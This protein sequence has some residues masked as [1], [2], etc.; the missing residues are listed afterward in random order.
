VTIQKMAIHLRLAFAACVLFCTGVGL[1]QGTSTQANAEKTTKLKA[2]LAASPLLALVETNLPIQLDA[3]E[4]LG[5]VSWVA[6]DQKSGI[7]WLIQR[8][9]KADPVMAVDDE[10][11]VIHAFGK[12]LYTIPHAIRLDP[13]GNVWTVDAGSSTVIKFSPTGKK[14]MQIDV[15]GM[16]AGCTQFCGTTDITFAPNGH[17][18]ISDG[19]RNARILEYAADGTKVREW[20][21]RGTGPGEFHLPHSIV[22]DEN[23]ILYVADRE[24]GRIE[25]FDLDGK[26]LGEI[27]TLGRTY[28][29][30]LGPKG[31]LWAGVAPLDEPTGAAGWLVK[32]DR[33][34]GKLLGYVPVTDKNGLHSVEID[35][36]GNPMTVV[37]NKVIMFKP[38]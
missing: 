38:R 3:G 11:N 23:N 5:K 12:G 6:R 20:G 19:Y 33:T 10:G 37:D 22:V 24:N 18:F 30:K 26:F 1:A 13:Q 27:P 15:G 8:G 28:C 31:T 7:T 4:E 36:D 17:I 35:G 2:M 14:L 21:T 34:S 25:K 29:L 16:P 32:L 9:D